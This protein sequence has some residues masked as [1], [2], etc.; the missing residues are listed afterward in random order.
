MI[1]GAPGANEAYLLWGSSDFAISC[2]TGSFGTIDV[3]PNLEDIGDPKVRR[4]F[5]ISG[6]T[7]GD[8]LGAAVAGVGDFNADGKDDILIGAP[9]GGAGKAY[10]IYGTTGTTD[11]TLSTLT[12]AQGFVINGETS[13]D[14]F[15]TAVAGGDLNN[16]GTPELIIG[17]PSAGGTGKVYVLFGGQGVGSTGSVNVADLT[18]TEAVVLTGEA[19]GDKVGFSVACVADVDSDGVYD[20]L[21]GAPGRN[22]STGAAYL[23]YGPEIK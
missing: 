3:S 10:V 19:A 12:A 4:G 16:D 13:G 1:V 11:I 23:V 5:K 22:S 7:A 8:R 2:G 6:V 9:A 14:L 15:G 17:A 18:A 20:L 21:I